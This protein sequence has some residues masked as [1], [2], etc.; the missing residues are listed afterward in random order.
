MTPQINSSAFSSRLV[1]LS[2]LTTLVFSNG[3]EDIDIIFDTDVSFVLCPS[4]EVIQYRALNL[5][6]WRGIK[7]GRKA[8][9]IFDWETWTQDETNTA[10]RNLVAA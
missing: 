8:F 4:L 3:T 5:E 10:R 2:C 7:T 6:F 1:G 9:R